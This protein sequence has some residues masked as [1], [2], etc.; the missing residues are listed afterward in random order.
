MATVWQSSQVSKIRETSDGHT[1]LNTILPAPTPRVAN[2]HAENTIK[3]T[4]QKWNENGNRW[5]LL[6]V[7]GICGLDELFQFKILILSASAIVKYYCYT[8]RSHNNFQFQSD[9]VF[10]RC[11]VRPRSSQTSSSCMMS[12][13]FGIRIKVEI[14][15][16][17]QTEIKLK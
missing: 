3:I 12:R 6:L 11:T 1:W 16:V 8:S 4:Q 2:I 9:V 15:S 13:K 17:Y 14:I 10:T 5:V 7:S